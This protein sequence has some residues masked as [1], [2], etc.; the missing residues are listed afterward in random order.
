MKTRTKKIIGWS[1]VALV[2]VGLIVG[3]ILTDGLYTSTE[4]ISE[5]MKDAVLHEE[6]QVDI[7]GFKANPGLVSAYIVTLILLVAA[8]LIRIFAIPKFKAVPGK[9]QLVA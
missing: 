8:A 6:N 7:F 3:I 5:V 1:V 4:D 2:V 9:F